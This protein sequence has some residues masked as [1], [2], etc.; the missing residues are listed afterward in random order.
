MIQQHVITHMCMT[1]D[2]SFTGVCVHEGRLWPQRHIIVKYTNTVDGFIPD[3]SL[4]ASTF[5]E[6]LEASGSPAVL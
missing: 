3:I 5:H 1:V 4:S 6:A 2:R